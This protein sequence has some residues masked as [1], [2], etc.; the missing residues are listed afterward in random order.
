M[1]VAKPSGGCEILT[2]NWHQLISAISVATHSGGEGFRQMGFVQKT[3]LPKGLAKRAGE[4]C[5]KGYAG[6][7]P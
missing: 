3:A 5:R 2:T 7:L 4:Y 1:L 6:L